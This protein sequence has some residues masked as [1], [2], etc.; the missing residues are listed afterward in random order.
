MPICGRMIALTH[1][2]Q[3]I[4]SK[5][6]TGLKRVYAL[7]ELE[8]SGLCVTTR[9]KFQSVQ[10]FGYKGI[11]QTKYIYILKLMTKQTT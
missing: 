1:L 10:R 7:W 5:L 3:P 6:C 8:R 9:N 2:F 11:L 4:F